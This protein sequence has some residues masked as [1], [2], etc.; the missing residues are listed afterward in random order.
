V[1]LTTHSHL[2]PRVR[3]SRTT[4]TLDLRGLCQGELYLNI[5]KNRREIVIIDKKIKQA[6][7]IDVATPDS[8]LLHGIINGKL[9]RPKRYKKKLINIWQ[10]KRP[11]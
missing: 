11:V 8:L 4:P 2:T 1:T 5:R 6:H 3:R 9:P 10:L 7:F